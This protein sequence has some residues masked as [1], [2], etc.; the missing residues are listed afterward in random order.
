MATTT[1]SGRRW[2]LY[3]P[4][5][6]ANR[7][8]SFRNGNDVLVLVEMPDEDSADGFRADPRLREAMQRAGVVGKADIDGPRDRAV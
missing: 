8:I 7:V 3:D 1:A 2:P 5:R 4:A 6:R